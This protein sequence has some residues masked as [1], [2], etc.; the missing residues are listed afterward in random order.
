MQRGQ[1]VVLP[2]QATHPGSSSRSARMSAA[3]TG[4]RQSSAVAVLGRDN[5]S[6]DDALTN[7]LVQLIIVIEDPEEQCTDSGKLPVSRVATFRVWIACCQ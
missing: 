6:E 1:T 2:S 4:N 7:W 5:H 3:S